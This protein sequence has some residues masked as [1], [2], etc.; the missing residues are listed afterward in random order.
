MNKQLTPSVVIIDNFLSD[1]YQTREFALSQ[2]FNVVG[3][4]PGARTP[5]FKTNEEKDAFEK[6]LNTKITWWPDSYNGSYQYVTKNDRSWIHRDNT[7]FSAILFLT[8]NPPPNTGTK[9]YVHKQSGLT[10]RKDNAVGQFDKDSYNWSAWDVMDVIENRF[11]RLVIFQGIVSHMSADYFGDSKENGRLFKIWFF[12]T[13]HH[14]E[15]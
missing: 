7:S 15:S 13:A 9:T 11:N 5:S 2:E 3:N 1:P 12:E 4:F 6:I 14:L 10:L 8:P